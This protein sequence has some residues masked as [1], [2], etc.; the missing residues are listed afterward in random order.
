MSADDATKATTPDATKTTGLKS[1]FEGLPKPAQEWIRGRYN[2]VKGLPGAPADVTAVVKI[3]KEQYDS[4]LL[5]QATPENR[6]RYASMMTNTRLI[7][8][9]PSLKPIPRYEVCLLFR[10]GTRNIKAKDGKTYRDGATS[11]TIR[12]FGGIGI[13]ADGHNAQ[14]F[15][16]DGTT[17]NEEQAAD[18]DN[19]EL[20]KW[21]KVGLV[22]SAKSKGVGKTISL[23]TGDATAWERAEDLDT[24]NSKDLLEAVCPVVNL[25]SI[26]RHMNEVV[27]LK[28]LM[29]QDVTL[30]KNGATATVSYVDESFLELPIARQ[31][32]I[33]AVQTA[34]VPADDI[35]GG[36]GSEV[37]I[38]AKVRPRPA[39]TLAPGQKAD[40]FEG[41]T[42]DLIKMYEEGLTTPVQAR[43]SGNADDGIGEEPSNDGMS[44]GVE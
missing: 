34:F 44:N 12:S 4:P 9:T 19:L 27:M 38:V 21:Y 3:F 23:T 37:S 41:L 2:G 7:K 29:I 8:G 36:P 22:R 10:G 40:E 16:L 24:R 1:F 28:K 42:L 25:A 32:K 30:G 15:F 33:G 43:S 26:P 13:S 39:G 14:P 11:L 18:L 31:A 35:V 6:L 17:F 20:G 5:A